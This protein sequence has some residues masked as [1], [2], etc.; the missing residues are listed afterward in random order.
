MYSHHRARLESASE[1]YPDGPSLLAEDVATIVPVQASATRLRLSAKH[2][3]TQT[4]QAMVSQYSGDLPSY[5]VSAPSVFPSDAPERPVSLAPSSHMP[6]APTPVPPISVTRSP[7]PSA[8][9][10][11]DPV[12]SPPPVA[13]PPPY[14]FLC[15][16]S[17]APVHGDDDEEQILVKTRLPGELPEHVN[18]LFLET[19]Q[20]VS[21]THLTLPTIYSV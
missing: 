8:L 16:P 13:E 21:Y 11:S 6:L 2:Q 7:D 15:P 9:P 12:C 19:I 20:P 1:E 17:T 3:S 4:E 5:G 14:A 18:L 10:V